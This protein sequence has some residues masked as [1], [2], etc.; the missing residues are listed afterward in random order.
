MF[1]RKEKSKTVEVT[2]KKN[3]E[4]VLARGSKD[5][6]DM[7]APPSFDR[8]F[9][10][11]MKVGDKYARS[12]IMHG[13]PSNVSVGWLD[14]LYSYDGD[15][16]TQIHIQPSDDRSAL[17]ELTHKITQFE[18]QLSTETEKGSIR[19]V[20]R[21]QNIVRQ[22][23]AQRERIE[24]NY[25]N[26]FHVQIATNLYTDSVESLDKETKKLDNRL[27]GRKIHHM[28]V[29][30]RQDD[31][32]KS[33][34]P[35]ANSYVPDKFRNFSTGA[36]TACFPFYN[37]EIS[38]PTGV[39]SGVNMSTRT[40]MYLDFYDRDLLGNSNLT[41]FGKAGSGKTFLVNLLTLRSAIKG[42]RSVIIDPEGEYKPLAYAL[43]GSYVKIAPDSKTK[44][45]PFD[46]EEEEEE[47]GRKVVNLKAK[48]AD[49]LNLIGVMAGSM[50]Q[51][52]LSIVSYIIAEVYTNAGFTDSPSSL[53]VTEPKFDE[54]TGEFTFAGQKKDMP[55]FSDFHILLE[56]YAKTEQ[57]HDIKTLANGL[58]MFKKGGVYDMFDTQTSED[59]KKLKSSPV[60]VFDISALEENVLR[61]IGMYVSMSWTWEKFVKKDPKIKK[62]VICD[63]AWM[64]VNKNMP[65]NEY[66][67]QFLENAARR[68]RKRNGGLLVASQNFIEFADNPQGKAVLTNAS[69]NIFL[70]QDSTDIDALQTT[71]KLS[72][73][74]K[75][76]LLTANKGQ[77]LLKMREES[78][79][80]FAYAFEY[81]K[82]LIT[83]AYAT[84]V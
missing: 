17:D 12:F 33:A 35:Y 64:L 57:N 30:L 24:Q 32:Y 22:L 55:T 27:R 37:S 14:E 36:L 2:P 38:H 71:F 69:V 8:S 72:D 77:F 81:E 34:L 70:Q 23:Y 62:R 47:D 78:S 29:Y 73:G 53:Y 4:N 13:F 83:S 46:L 7:F 82:N 61:P 19:N 39:F 42:I 20:T 45:N 56:E 51:E 76:F 25:E 9:E 74:E 59:L 28:P 80:G 58:K 65:G 60:V 50:T 15:M 75:N 79:V 63:E 10:D 26:L 21:L 66:T 18:A 49:V 16:D 1:K 40:P 52:Q 43:K 48:I 67:S 6:K 41:V 44:L 68:I 11:Y 3:A 84:Q 54:K 31:G 5:I